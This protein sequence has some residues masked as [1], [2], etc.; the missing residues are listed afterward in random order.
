[1]D[2]LKV[3]KFIVRT[4]RKLNVGEKLKVGEETFIVVKTENM[5]G[6]YRSE[7]V[8]VSLEWYEL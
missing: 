3:E 7:L 2:K 6:H 1:M 5:L 8:N 4:G